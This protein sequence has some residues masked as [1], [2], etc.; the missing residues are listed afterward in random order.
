MGSYMIKEAFL[1]GRKRHT[2]LLRARDCMAR[3]LGPEK[4]RDFFFFMLEGFKPHLLLVRTEHVISGTWYF[5]PY[6]RLAIDN[7]TN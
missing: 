7:S 6:N 4:F 1:L 2:H 3:H 5:R